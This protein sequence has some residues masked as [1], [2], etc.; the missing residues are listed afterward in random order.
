MKRQWSLF[1]IFLLFLSACFFVLSAEPNFNGYTIG[2]IFFKF[3]NKI[4][5]ISTS[6]Y[7]LLLR[8]KEGD[9]YDYKNIRNSMEN[10]IKT[11]TI[12][13][14][15]I[16]VKARPGRELDIFFLITEKSIIQSIRTREVKKIENQVMV[17]PLPDFKKSE[18]M[19][20]IYSLRENTYFEESNLQEA[21]KEL[22][23]FLN[24]K[25]FFNPQI[26]PEIKKS[27]N[28]KYVNIRLNIFP[29]F[30]TR[31]RHSEYIF[32]GKNQTLLPIIK[33]ILDSPVYAP[34]KYEE[35]IGKVYKTLKKLDYYIPE[36][37]VKENFID[38][39]KTQ[40][41]LT[42]NI[43]LGPQYIF[44]YEGIK[45]K[46]GLI[47]QIW[48]KKVFEKWAE[49]ESESRI[50]LDL[51][52][53]GYLDASVSS[54]IMD[55]KE[56]ETRTILFK[57]DKKR[58]YK[59]G[60][61]FISG[62]QAMPES[63]LFSL[64]HTD[65]SFYHK[66][67]HL[68]LKSLLVDRE[69]LRLFYYFNGFPTASISTEPRFNNGRADIFFNIKEGKKYTVDMILFEGNH[70][71]AREKLLSF[72]QTREKNIFVQ[73]R[74]DEDIEKLRINYIANGYD[75][76][77]INSDVTPGTEKTILVRIKEGKPFFMGDLITIGGSSQQRKLIERLFPLKKGEPF[78]SIKV[79]EFRSEIE[80]SSLFNEFHLV[81]I[82]RDPDIYD[83]LI[84]I[85]ADYSKYYGFGIGW[86][87]RKNIR[88][89]LE[90]QG[91]N[92]FGSY[93]TL[94]GLVQ[95]GPKE[96]SGVISYDTPYFFK[97][98][99]NSSLKLW[100]DYEIYPSYKFNRFGVGESL[101]KK[102]NPNSYI[103][104]A[105]SW[106]R[107]ELTE[108]EITPHAIDQLHVPF[109]TTALDFTYVNER[110]DDPFNPTQGTFFSTD[111]KIG[112]PVFEKKYSF[113]KATWSYQR[114]FP[115]FNGGVLTTSMRTGI[116][117]GD[118]SITERFFAGGYNSFRAS[119]KDRLGPI[120]PNTD[121]PRG[122]NALLLFNFEATFPISILPI[123]GFYYTTFIDIGNVYQKAGDFDLTNMKKGIGLSLKYKT[124]MGP[125]RF[126]VAWDMKTWK[127]E[128]Q[129]GIG[130]VF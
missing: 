74:F 118:L 40:V 130:N 120:D 27:S 1:I 119:R 20:A 78:N 115:L 63:R 51:K 100:A 5:S 49:K 81:K 128:F 64:I 91:R 25:G 11:G 121:N 83:L 28:N 84:R 70:F 76:V 90:Y 43:E 19:G 68:R 14:I 61:I 126:D 44:K 31:V 3:E 41:D 79:D 8:F 12:D 47:D 23:T 88:G 110:R 114:N 69:I 95:L 46:T 98:R 57:V 80:N 67:F 26:E 48:Q 58:K 109:D 55:D 17:A 2:N 99:I 37:I 129:I 45:D 112:L 94:S 13:N 54:S 123:S 15:E 82:E 93:S 117:T 24:G 4:E 97:T 125:L 7:R 127:P 113:V 77:E 35:N 32:S 108:L 72:M 124:R 103:M 56:K 33:K 34:V 104:G 85:N 66:Y 59:L 71:F 87:G 122:G 22:K 101:I 36:I 42:V 75:K 73:Q 30:R 16:R 39:K 65:D 102:L 38:E 50:L 116:A 62:N 96:Q 92:V 53:D 10:L 106:Y 86:E 89:T 21:I 52:N 18:L 111:V 105:L 60:K 9:Q 107:T 29:G 6:K